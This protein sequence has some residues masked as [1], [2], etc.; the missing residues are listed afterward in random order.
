MDPA[1]SQLAKLRP[2]FAV[3]ALALAVRA[4]Y[5]FELRDSP[6]F[7]TLLGDGRQYWAWAE[8]LAAGDW[9]GDGVF[10]Q[11]PLYPYFLAAIRTFC[12]PGVWPVRL[13][14]I[15]LGSASCALLA[16]AG[17][18]FFSPGAG[19]AAGVLL[20]LYPPAIFFDG[21]VQKASLSLFFLTLLLALTGHLEAR[22]RPR[23]LVVLGGVLG[24]LALVRE[25]A[26]ILAP[27][28]GLWLAFHRRAPRRRR[29]AWI[30]LFGLGLAA[31]LLAAGTRNLVAGGQFVLTTSQLGTNFYVGNNPG[32]NGRYRP[33]RPGGGD[34]RVERRDAEELAEAAAGRSLSAREVSAFWLHQSL[35]YIAER[36]LHWGGLLL[37]K[38][39]LLI[40]AEE[41]VD[42]ESIEV[43]RE[44]S[45]LLGL[46]S[47]GLHF[48]VLGPLAALG[49]WLTRP[50][51]RELGILYAIAAGLALSVVLFYVL[52]RY[53]FSLVPLAALFAGAALC[54]AWQGLTTGAARPLL[55]GLPVL[56]LAAVAMNWPLD[57]PSYGRA[58][59]HYNLGVNFFA[60]GRSELARDYLEKAL[61][62]LDAEPGGAAPAAV[63]SAAH[64]RLGFLLTQDGDLAAASEHLRQALATDPDHAMA[65]ALL[66]N[67]LA[68]QGDREAARRHYATALEGDAK[69][70]DAHFKLAM[71][72]AD[73]GRLEEAGE[74]LEATLRA[75]PDFV[76]AHLQ[77]AGVRE[78]QGRDREAAAA[79]RRALAL[80]PGDAATL[81]RLA[82]LLATSRDPA[83]RDGTAAIELARR[84]CR[85]TEYRSATLLDV[86]AAALAESGRFDEAIAAARQAVQLAAAVSRQS[87]TF[88]D[89]LELYLD[90]RPLRRAAAAG[91][92]PGCSHRSGA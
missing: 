3:F 77:L 51:W 29:G 35:A 1:N 60:E 92:P 32:A 88:R 86:L 38:A 55:S 85:A 64:F 2:C 59:T 40:H 26:L 7:L 63:L 47:A 89:H 57:S 41:V 53:R 44:E 91:T 23:P 15:L 56:A 22:M 68:Q 10:Y 19:I 28:F 37:R 48:G 27:I 13:I 20:A 62:D 54:L 24:C 8:R 12:G 66:G 90:G 67:V 16:A 4:L 79:Y 31:P 30:A 17:R 14:Q 33:L 6:L 21:L 71:L 39:R 34:A 43:Y 11:A 9:L 46:L 75:V 25:N 65:H 58:T 81:G 36:P 70:A 84:A 76:A 69:L 72:L 83:A 52:A 45:R 87:A 73:D 82:S 50:R 42:S 49:L 18:R 74:H 80:A 5:L 78:R 61:A